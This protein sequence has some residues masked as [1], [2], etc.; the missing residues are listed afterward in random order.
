MTR[1]ME[2]VRLL[3]VG[4]FW[5]GAWRHSWLLIGTGLAAILAAWARGLLRRSSGVEFTSA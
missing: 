4:L 3:G 1:G 5:G 2:A